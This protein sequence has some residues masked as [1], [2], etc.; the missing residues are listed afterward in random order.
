MSVNILGYNVFSE[1]KEEL[2]KYITTYEKKLNI[3]SGNPEILYN[4]LNNELLYN[5]FTGNNSLIIPDGIGTVI[6]SKI[7]GHRVKEKIAGIEVM[8]EILQYCSENSKEVYLLGAK[9]DIL[10]K[11]LANLKIKYPKLIISGKHD[12]FFNMEN[13]KEVLEDIK[14]CRPYVIFVAMGSPR[15]ELFIIK[16][17]EELPCNIFMGV[18]GSFDVIAGNVKRAP[19]WMISLGLE[20]VYRVLKEPWR[21]KRLSSI[22][23]FLWKVFLRKNFSK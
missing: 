12:G 3:I 19:K 13:C 10:N 22:P 8:A 11:C 2:L 21:I 18:G 16:Y 1:S 5:N 17:M 15:Q 9:E 7:V 14:N 20:W 6:S 4:G 23:K